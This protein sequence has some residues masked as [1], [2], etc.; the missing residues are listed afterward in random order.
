[1]VARFVDSAGH[2]I[3]YNVGDA[4][5]DPA[6][7]RSR[8][9]DALA[10]VREP[11]WQPGTLTARSS[12]GRWTGE[13]GDAAGARDRFAAPFPV[14]ERIL[15]P[16]HPNTLN[17]RANLAYWTEQRGTSTAHRRR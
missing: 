16:E 13:A 10:V 11:D 2:E 5:D 3:A 6:V 1:M 12:L 7:A 15:D 4:D 14:R 8:V 9:R 17:A